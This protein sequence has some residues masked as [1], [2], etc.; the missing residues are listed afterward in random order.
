MNAVT[1]LYRDFTCAA[2]AALITLVL[3]MAFVESTSA[4][5]AVQS[6]TVTA[7]VA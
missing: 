7:P 3:G 1:A 6:V 2:A 5:P 4:A